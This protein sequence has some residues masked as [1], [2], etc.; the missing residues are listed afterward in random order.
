MRL[1]VTFL[2]L[3]SI[4]FAASAANTDD[5]SLSPTQE[6]IWLDE[7]G[8]HER[9]P[10]PYTPRVHI[11]GNKALI[12][13]TS[14]APEMTQCFIQGEFNLSTVETIQADS[15]CF[16]GESSNRIQLDPNVILAKVW[17]VPENQSKNC[18]TVQIKIDNRVNQIIFNKNIP[19]GCYTIVYKSQ[20]PDSKK[21]KIPALNLQGT[22]YP[23]DTS[24]KSYFENYI[25]RATREEIKH[26]DELLRGW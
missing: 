17:M 5:I 2:S 19:H 8:P 21:F 25:P 10:A 23:A 20:N 4:S 1:I 15:R 11:L 18:R 14:P 22:S 26:E 12:V 3:L 13:Q 6:E 7:I 24:I 9:M 16:Y